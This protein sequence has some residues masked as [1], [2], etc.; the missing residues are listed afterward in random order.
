M[1][2][3]HT[4]THDATQPAM[5]AAMRIA[6][7]GP[8]EGSKGKRAACFPFMCIRAILNECKKHLG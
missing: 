7:G 6:A 2:A 5:A 4:G 8:A 3:I 1:A